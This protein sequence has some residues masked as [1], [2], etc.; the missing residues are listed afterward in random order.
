MAVSG[1]KCCLK[2]ETTVP[3]K[4]SKYLKLNKPKH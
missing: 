2:M 4:M 1:L 3:G